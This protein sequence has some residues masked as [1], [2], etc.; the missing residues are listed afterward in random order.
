MRL[1]SG[2]EPAGAVAA[3]AAADEAA[4]EGAV[5]PGN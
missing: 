5:P 3:V 1:A 2:S 4:A